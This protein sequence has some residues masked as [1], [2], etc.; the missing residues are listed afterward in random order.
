MCPRRRPGGDRIP[1]RVRMVVREEPPSLRPV[2]RNQGERAT[3]AAFL[4]GTHPMERE[5]AAEHLSADDADVLLVQ[6]ARAR[7]AG[8]D[9]RAF[10]GLRGSLPPRWS[11][12]D[13]A[14]EEMDFAVPHHSRRTR[15]ARLH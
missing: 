12:G 7:S 8:E 2:P 1:G 15:L 11:V 5:A 3:P 10:G 9:E 6:P 4:P 13:A 14:K